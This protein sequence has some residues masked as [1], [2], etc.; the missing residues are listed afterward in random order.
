L[1][2]RSFLC[3]ARSAAL[4][5]DLSTL[6]DTVEDQG[7]QRIEDDQAG[8]WLPLAEAAAHIGVSVKTVRR[9]LKAGELT[10]RQVA[11]QHGQAYEVW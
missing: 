6:V 9:R 7:R 11:T 4:R 10:S 5:H 8:E 1:G 3:R 2:R